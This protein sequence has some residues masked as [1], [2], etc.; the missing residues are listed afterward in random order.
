MRFDKDVWFPLESSLNF[1]DCIVPEALVEARQVEKFYAQPHGCWLD[2]I[3]P[4]DLDDAGCTDATLL[5]VN[6]ALLLGT[7]LARMPHPPI[8]PSAIPIK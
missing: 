4:T 5:P 2:I 6:V 7:L 1:G 8:R 3:A